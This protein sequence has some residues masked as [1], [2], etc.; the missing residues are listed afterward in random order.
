MLSFASSGSRQAAIT[1]LALSAAGITAPALAQQAPPPG[2][3]ASQTLPGQTREEINRIPT[4]PST[5]GGPR[6]SIEGEIQR[7]PCPLA[8]P[9]FA[10]ITVT[11]SGAEFNGLRVVSP[12]VLRPAYESFIGQTVPIAA[13]CEIRDAAATIL[14]QRG[15]L[16]AVQVPP[17]QITD[18]VVRFDVLMGKIV[19]IQV[20]GDAGKSERIIAGYLQP[21][22]SQEAFNERDAERYLLLARDLPGYDVRLTLRPAGTT[23]GELIG[24]VS[25]V[26]TPFVIDANVI[27]YGSH[28]VG[29]WGGLVRAEIYDILGSGDRLTVGA[30]S[31]ADYDEQHVVQLGYDLRLGSEGLVLS[32]RFSH[33][34]SEPDLDL[35]G[36]KIESKTLTAAAELSYPLIRSQ[37]ANLRAAGGLEFVNQRTRLNDLFVSRDRLSVAYLRFDFD[38]IDRASIGSVAGYSGSEPRWRVGGSVE[39]RHGL[40]IFGASN[41]CRGALVRTCDSIDTPARTFADA[42][43]FVFRASGA[44]EWR[45]VPKLTFFLAPRWQYSH[46]ALYSY[47]RFSAGS[48]TIGRGYDP[49]T[50]V[51]D[52]GVGFQAEVRYGTLMPRSRDSFAFQGFVFVDKAWT[53]VRKEL[54]EG[55]NL[56]LLGGDPYQLTTVGGGVRA[57]FGDHARLDV[58]FAV[59]VDKSRGIPA[60]DQRLLVSLTTRLWP[61]KR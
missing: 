18:G 6:L 8:D 23:P 3:P 25:V 21:L 31:T 59:P 12:D 35:P 27:N 13:V 36:L 58:T 55:L 9:R 51:G 10:D 5:Q 57:A 20:R 39:L 24:E 42:N 41:D 2:S 17:Q 34:W 33:A 14:R 48:Y 32:G 1:A 19:A 54:N 47:E 16:A 53:W 22:K 4:T 44:A 56:D 28:A 7:A 46:D 38:A 26:S 49:G 15:F 29:R 45:P 43:A 60:P 11:L 37:G 40:E 52:S 30:F 50:L 61:W